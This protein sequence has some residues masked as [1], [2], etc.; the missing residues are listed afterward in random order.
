MIDIRPAGRVLGWLVTLL[1]ATMILPAGVDLIDRD[2]NS[3][4]FVLSMLVTV[5]TGASVALACGRGRT[6]DLDLRQGFLLVTATWIAFTAFATLP[7]MLGEP[8]IS[9]TDAVFET[10]SAMTTTGGT[11][12]IG[13]ETLPRGV[14]LW[15]G[16]LQWIGGIG[17]ILLAMILLPVLKIG[18]M[19]LLRTSDFNTMGKVLPKAKEI[20]A[21]FGAVYV[22]LTAACAA[23]FS[24]AGMSGFDAVVHAMTTIATGGMA[25]YDSS[26]TRF[27]PAAQYI[28]IIFMLAG[29]MSFVRF[30][31]FARGDAGALMR[32][33]QIRAYLL[34]FALF[35]IMVLLARALRGEELNELAMREAFF[36]VAS[37]QSTTGFATTDYQTWGPLAI[38]LVFCVGMICGCSGSTAGGPK[39]FRYQIMLGAI[40]DEMRFLHSP[41]AVRALRFQG[42]AVGPEV[43]ASVMGFFMM[44][45]LT[46]GA[47]SILLVLMGVSPVTAISGVATCLSNV[48]PGLGPEIGPAGNFAGLADPVKWVLTLVMLVGRLEILT[49]YVLFTGAF[50]RS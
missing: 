13:L 19:Q 16:L 20:A 45:F 41:H 2:P 42:A 18:G 40:A 23:G 30:L 48:G 37:I 34:V 29:G 27:T 22:T 25:N 7:L 38:A 36:T 24:W 10:M 35:S 28:A 33:T 6:D 4:A 17:V 32:D 46:L 50:W 26:F 5:T 47:A 11:V 9:F 12:L 49:V 39:V 31:Q 3:G 15:R 1:G 43:V 21:A 44:F 14:L 8:S